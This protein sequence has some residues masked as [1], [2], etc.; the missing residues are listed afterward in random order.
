MYIS[1][2]YYKEVARAMRCAGSSDNFVF[3]ITHNEKE[4]L[5]FADFEPGDIRCWMCICFERGLRVESD[6]EI[7]KLKKWL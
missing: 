5:F 3:E 4:L 6:F 7:D 2:K 1:Q